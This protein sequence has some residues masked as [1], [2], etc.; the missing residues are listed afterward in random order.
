[1]HDPA[2]ERHA[3]GDAVATGDKRSLAQD[4]PIL[5]IDGVIRHIAIDLALAHR[6]PAAFGTA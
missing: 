1:M 3:P 6:D 2:F 4:R 5:V